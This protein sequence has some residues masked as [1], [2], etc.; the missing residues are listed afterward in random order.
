MSKKNGF[1]H[2]NIKRH[3]QKKAGTAMMM[4]IVSLSHTFDKNN[5]RATALSF[6]LLLM[7]TGDGLGGS[8]R[9]VINVLC[10]SPDTCTLD[11]LT[12]ASC[13]CKNIA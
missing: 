10:R 6:C 13:F 9:G 12:H 3:S 11:S 7:L 2:E 1:G 8:G 5:M 4:Q